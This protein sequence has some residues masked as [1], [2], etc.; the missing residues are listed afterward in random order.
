VAL[1]GVVSTFVP[2]LATADGYND[3]SG[4]LP[5][6]GEIYLV[7][8]VQVAPFG[9]LSAYWQMQTQTGLSRRADLLFSAAGWQ[10]NTGWTGDGFYLQPRWQI[11]DNHLVSVGM[12]VPGSV[13]GG[14]TAAIPGLFSTFWLVPDRW[15][16]NV[17]A[18]V[19]VPWSRPAA[20]NHYS[21]LVLERRL[22]D[23]LGVYV[24]ADIYGRLASVQQTADL[25]IGLQWDVGANDTFNLNA[26]LLPL[27]PGGDGLGAGIG[28]GLWYARGL[29]IAPVQTVF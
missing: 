7:P 28:V 11:A 1:V 27:R 9:G 4:E 15:K 8:A 29:S 21:V 2:G 22:G 10:D 17:N 12:W 25:S 19:Y 24:E 14:P 6:P 3:W 26:L 23:S 13:Q 18:T 5:D 20:S 16:L